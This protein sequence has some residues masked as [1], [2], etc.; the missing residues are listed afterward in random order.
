MNKT[1]RNISIAVLSICLL[2][3]YTKIIWQYGFDTGVDV[4]LCVVASLQNNGTLAENDESCKSVKTDQK[5]PLWALRRGS[6][7]Q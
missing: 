1:V 3:G 4:S 5:N 7:A 6:A 2:I